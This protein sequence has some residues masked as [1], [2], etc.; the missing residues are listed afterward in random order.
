MRSKSRDRKLVAL[1]GELYERL[2]ALYPKEYR[3]EYGAP[4]AQL[5][6]DQCRDA[7]AEARG[8]G[9]AGLWLRILID[10]LK[11]SILEHLRSF[12]ERRSMFS[13]AL[14]L[15][16]SNS[17]PRI[18]FL[19]LFG[20]VFPLALGFS[21]LLAFLA[22]EQYASTVRMKVEQTATDF[23]PG[24]YQRYVRGNYDPYFFQNQFE[25]IQSD[26]VL[27]EV[28][29]KLNL[30]ESWG[31]TSVSGARLG[32]ADV[33]NLLRQRVELRPVL[34][35]SLIEIRIFS[36]DPKEASNIANALAETYR[37][38]RSDEPPRAARAET[39][40]ARPV[41]IVD[42]AVPGLRPVRPNKPATLFM[43]F[44]GGILL[45]MVVGGF[46]ASLVLLYRRRSR[47]P[48]LMG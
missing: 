32:K 38:F 16:R 42:R 4:M 9:L 44:V 1:S 45:A 10:L 27:A 35:T 5:F 11:T 6:R 31:K 25:L 17:G 33:I 8:W 47:P 3:R 40:T 43:G 19:A 7:W 13:K 12:S 15:F 48:V 41:E 46:G 14:V 30:A 23:T 20:M 18:T 28:S 37:E 22:P 36:K 29:R 26:S 24:S 2:L 34:N 21:V 39:L